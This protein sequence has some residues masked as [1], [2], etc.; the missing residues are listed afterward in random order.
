MKIKRGNTEVLE[1]NLNKDCKRVCKLMEADEISVKF[2]RANAI[3]LKIG[4]YVV[5][6]ENGTDLQFVLNRPYSPK[7]NV[8]NGAYE[9]EVTF[10]AY[11]YKWQNKILKYRPSS[12]ASEASFGLTEVIGVHA[13]M[14]LS[15]ILAVE[16]SGSGWSVVTDNTITSQQREVQYSNTSILDSLGKIA[17][18]FK[19]EWWVV[20]KVVHFGTCNNGN[21]A[22]EL[23]LNGNVSDMKESKSN[24]VYATRIYPFGSDVNIPDHYRKVLQFKVDWKSETEDH[25]IRLNKPVTPDMFDGIG[26]TGDVSVWNWIAYPQG[27][28]W[29]TNWQDHQ[30]GSNLEWKYNWRMDVQQ[31]GRQTFD[32]PITGRIPCYIDAFTMGVRLKAQVKYLNGTYGSVD[33]Y[34]SVSAK[35]VPYIANSQNAG[36]Q[37]M[38]LLTSAPEAVSAYSNYLEKAYPNIRQKTLSLMYDTLYFE[39]SDY[40]ET[41]RLP[42]DPLAILNLTGVDC[43]R[44]SISGKI[45][46]NKEMTTEITPQ[47]IQ[48]GYIYIDQ[49]TGEWWGWQANG[50][51]EDFTPIC[52]VELYAGAATLTFGSSEKSME[53][54]TNKGTMVINPEMLP[55][56]DDDSHLLSVEGD[57]SAVNVGDT[58]IIDDPIKANI[59]TGWFEIKDRDDSVKV[60][61]VSRNLRLPDI[62]DSVDTTTEPGITITSNYVQDTSVND[63]DVVEMVALFPDEF[64][65]FVINNYSVEAKTIWKKYQNSDE[66]YEMLQYYLTIPSLAGFDPKYIIGELKIVFLSGSL[67]GMT[68]ELAFVESDANGGVFAIV[69]NEEY[70]RGLP[71]EIAHPASTAPLDSFVITGIDTTFQEAGSI[72]DAEES[73]LNSA[74]ESLKQILNYKKAYD[75]YL[76]PS[77]AKENFN[78]IGTA[79]SLVNDAM[80]ATSLTSRVY[81]YEYPLDKRYRNFV[82][83]VGDSSKY[84]RLD[85]LEAKINSMDVTGQVYSGGGGS[86]GVSIQIIKSTDDTEATDDNVYSALKAVNEFLSRTHDDTMNGKLTVTKGV[87]SETDVEA[88]KDVKAGGNMQAGGGMSAGGIADLLKGSGGGQGTVKGVKVGPNGQV[89]NPD[90]NGVVEIPPYPTGPSVVAYDDLDNESVENTS[91]V[92]TAFGVAIV[93]DNIGVEKLPTYDPEKVDGYYRGNVV[94]VREGSK[95]VGYRFKLRTPMGTAIGGRVER[96][97]FETLANPLNIVNIEDIL[98]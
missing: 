11:Y 53:V 41:E 22:V 16:G 8:R 54:T 86:Q 66:E 89:N 90:Q 61:V 69:P 7:R 5:Y 63:S 58:I 71:D 36:Q 72:E 91:R 64:P 57:W 56:L 29:R 84:S 24:D 26:G 42:L 47:T 60:G 65:R 46:T 30:S 31:S 15:N 83:Y 51:W 79:V 59:P 95:W 55:S 3:H 98:V 35:I 6:T 2:S 85:S 81:G 94:K 12:G 23:S 27:R 20:G 62:G 70:G 37:P 52:Y 77:Y 92:A 78:P 93:K 32:S 13:Q 49:F 34:A 43:W 50:Y 75:V 28:D 74:I 10:E 76:M 1:F 19:C 44:N 14:L 67:G 88:E 97:T 21:E 38:S 40:I 48:Q 25:Y 82:C 18:A 4:D 9:Y 96:L 17:E 45:Y 80:F 39:I 68:F 73:L 87:K 33:R